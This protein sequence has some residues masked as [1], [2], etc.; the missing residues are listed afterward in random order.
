[1]CEKGLVRVRPHTHALEGGSK[2]ALFWDCAARSG[3]RGFRCVSV[4]VLKPVWN[5]K[6]SLGCCACGFRQTGDGSQRL[7]RSGNVSR[8]LASCWCVISK[9]IGGPFWW[10]VCLREPALAY[11]RPSQRTV[12]VA[13][14]SRR[15]ALCGIC[16]SV[17]ILIGELVRK[18]V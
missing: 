5:S 4:S 15:V 12:F 17:T 7:D 11:Y 3:F 1:M 8:L 10:R 9:L 2:Q 14:S 6:P 13:A 18:L 16:V